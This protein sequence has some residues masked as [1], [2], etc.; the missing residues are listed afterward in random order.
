MGI[1]TLAHV[2]T[3]LGIIERESLSPGTQVK[4]F[5]PS[6]DRVAHLA[7]MGLEPRGYTIGDYLAKSIAYANRM[8]FSFENPFV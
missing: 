8:G 1:G 3:L 2:K 6:P 5:A 4:H 7:A